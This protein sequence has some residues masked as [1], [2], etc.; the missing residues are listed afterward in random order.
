MQE[1]QTPGDGKPATSARETVLSQLRDCVGAATQL[2]A[3]D[4]GHSLR[5]PPGPVGE[6]AVPAEAPATEL[7]LREPLRLQESLGR[8]GMGDVYEAEQASLERQIAI[9]LLHTTSARHRRHFLAEA[10]CQGLLEHPNI[11]PVHGLGQ[12]ETGVPFLAMKRVTGKT[13]AQARSSQPDDLAAQLEIL[14]QVCNAVAYAHSR[15]IIHCDLKP[16]NIMIGAFGEVLVVDWGLA[17]S[18]KETAEGS[19]IQHRSALKSLCGTPRYMP[20]ELARGDGL[21]VS[22]STDTYLLGGL[23]YWILSKRP[24]RSDSNAL[25]AVLQARDGEVDALDADL[26]AELVAICKQA[27]S[28]EPARR[29]A[30]AE[31]LRDAVRAYLRHRQSL[32][33][34]TQARQQLD[35]LVATTREK[36]E[37][38]EDL[39]EDLSQ[40]VAGFC[41]ARQ[42]W[43]A[44]PL[45]PGGE[46]EARLCYARTALRLGDLALARAQLDRAQALAANVGAPLQRAAAELE[47]LLAARRTSHRR[48][49]RNTRRLR[50]GLSAALATI[51]LGLLAA[52]FAQE[53]SRRA[54]EAAK[55]VADSALVATQIAQQEAE[56]ARRH[57]EQR[58]EI[59]TEALEELVFEVQT[60]LVHLPDTESRRLRREILSGARRHLTRLRDSD[61]AGQRLG[62]ATAIASLRLGGL[63]IDLD[64]DLD[65]ALAEIQRGR[66]LLARLP[67]EGRE[68]ARDFQ[69]V[70]ADMDLAMALARRGRTLEADSLFVRGIASLQRL[71]LSVAP[72]PRF[73][74]VQ[75]DLLENHAALLLD[76]GQLDRAETQAQAGLSPELAA[77]PSTRPAF[78]RLLAE[79]EAQRGPWQAAERLYG[80]AVQ[81]VRAQL[82]SRPGS[83]ALR[84]ELRAILFGLVAH[85]LAEGRLHE[86]QER[87]AELMPLSLGLLE[88][89]P[90]SRLARYQWAESLS[91]RSYL[92]AHSGDALPALQDQLES[93]AILEQLSAESLADAVMGYR[94]QYALQGLAG[95]YALCGDEPA[96]QAVG[97]RNLRLAQARLQ[98]N[99]RDNHARVLLVAAQ[100]EEAK[101]LLRAERAEEASEALILARHM[102]LDVVRTPAL[103]HALAQVELELGSS[104]QLMGDSDEARHAF[105]RARELFEGLQA[106]GRDIPNLEQDVGW[107]CT[108]LANHWLDTDPERAL[109]PATAAVAQL[110]RAREHAPDQ[111]ASIALGFALQN[112]GEVQLSLGNSEAAELAYAE[113]LRL[114]VPLVAHE[115]ARFLCVDGYLYASAL[116]SRREAW[117]VASDLCQAGLEL[118]EAASP[119]WAG[120]YRDYPPRFLHGL[121][122]CY[123]RLGKTELARQSLQEALRRCAALPPDE[124]PRLSV[125]VACEALLRELEE[126]P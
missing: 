86:A 35:A 75:A 72:D 103:D 8:G 84:L 78:L 45:V 94:A 63:L 64:G 82:E 15:G 19:R 29:Y 34:T 120:V 105:E 100:R 116:A 102:L 54:L 30:R 7:T 76:S 22:P 52:M 80:Q 115:S 123:L 59:A 91:L 122:L 71:R 77:D 53:R 65:A 58:G 9:K 92:R 106:A 25:V 113:L 104:Y 28:A 61:Y 51:V 118:A 3:L 11:V 112:L 81:E 4:P 93:A 125:E 73:V 18:M 66:D 40:A 101:A 60:G 31:E 26:P 43:A 62:Y 55:Q 5:R 20:P 36:P 12:T 21:A 126:R 121:G 2:E 110:T 37:G 87:L 85:L 39:Y 74:R 124:E 1:K 95:L 114:C 10:V 47:D 111:A 70:L 67:R 68:Q 33:L 90:E 79:I 57:A 27:L 109:E 88:A 107:C 41:Q 96:S 13:W 99:P 108:Q 14:V 46:F 24:P 17:L 117:Q 16:S 49:A 48:A 69:L 38:R 97:A 6:G 42:L 50:R 44:N 83:A 23:L 89:D 56:A 98:A 32:D 119:E